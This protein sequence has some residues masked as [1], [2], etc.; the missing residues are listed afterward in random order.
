MVSLR[1]LLSNGVA[2]E[3]AVLQLFFKRI[4]KVL[5]MVLEGKDLSV[6]KEAV[7]G[8]GLAAFSSHLLDEKIG[9]GP[10]LARLFS[11]NVSVHGARYS[12]ILSQHANML[13]VD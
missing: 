5:L 1:N 9:V 12:A 11:H 13:Q 4:C 8:A 2:A 6:V 10:M 3:N 7:V